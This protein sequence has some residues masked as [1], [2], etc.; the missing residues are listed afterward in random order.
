MIHG[1]ILL[2]ALLLTEKYIFSP[3]LLEKTDEIFSLLITLSS[4]LKPTEYFLSVMFEAST[5]VE[6]FTHRANNPSR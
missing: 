2:R 5:Y 4:R 6:L 1:E 3:E